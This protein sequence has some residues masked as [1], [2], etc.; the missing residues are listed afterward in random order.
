MVAITAGVGDFGAETLVDVSPLIV[1]KRLAL[2]ELSNF[3]KS[4]SVTRRHEMRRAAE[5]SLLKEAGR[6]VQTLAG[7]RTDG[8]GGDASAHCLDLPDISA[9]RM[10]VV[11]SVTR[12]R[13]LGGR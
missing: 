11:S 4:L 3:R 12:I 7:V 9:L 8:L 6:Q 1:H 5:I 13:C 2:Q 10:S